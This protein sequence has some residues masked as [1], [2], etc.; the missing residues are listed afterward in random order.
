MDN[1][2][3]LDIPLTHVGNVFGQLDKNVKIIE[4]LNVVITQR[5]DSIKISG[6]DNNATVAEEVIDELLKLSIHW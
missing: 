3:Q 4:E 2:I 5:G 1:E 6:S